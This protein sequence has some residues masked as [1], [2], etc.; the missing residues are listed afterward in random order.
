MNSSSQPSSRDPRNEGEFDAWIAKSLRATP[1]PGELRDVLKATQPV[2][3]RAP[4][5]SP[6]RRRLLVCAA[7]ACVM[8]AAAFLYQELRD[9]RSFAQESDFRSAVAHYIASVTFK[10]DYTTDNLPAILQYLRSTHTV[11]AEEI[12]TSLRQRIPKGCKEIAWG[13]YT[14]SLICFYETKPGGRLVHLFLINKKDVPRESLAALNT[15]LRRSSLETV[16]WETEQHAC[17]MVAGKPDMEI[18]PFL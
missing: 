18:A 15:L 7:A 14:I 8:F 4:R 11:A 1:V 2:P 10:L 5:S 12:P 17:V 6:W 3:E 16:G 9:R 13:R